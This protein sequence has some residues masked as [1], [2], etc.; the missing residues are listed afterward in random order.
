[1]SYINDQNDF[2]FD[3]CQLIKF[4]ILEGFQV[5]GSQFERPEELMLLYYYGYKIVEQNNDIKLVKTKKRS[6]TKKSI[7]GKRR[8]F[9]LNFFKDGIYINALPKEES[10]PILQP[11][12]NYF[13]MLH[14]K[15]KWGGEFKTIYDP[16]HF[17]RS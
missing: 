7:H 14:P 15:N 4:A 17:Q 1:M 13:K 3:V 11:L 12:A 6:K 10:K 2:L 9:D 5:T 8:A 16:D